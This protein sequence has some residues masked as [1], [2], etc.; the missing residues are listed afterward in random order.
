MVYNLSLIT[1]PNVLTQAPGLPIPSCP[2][3]DG[4]LPNQLNSRLP[5]KAAFARC[6]QE[7]DDLVS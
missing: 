5:G 3:R 2:L 6:L 7:P 4:T 1:D